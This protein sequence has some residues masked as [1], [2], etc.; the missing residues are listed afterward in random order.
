MRWID[1]GLV[2][3][4]ADWLH[5][6]GHST[7]RSTSW[8]ARFVVIFSC[9]VVISCTGPG[10]TLPLPGCGSQPETTSPHFT[11]PTTS[12]TQHDDG[13]QYPTNAPPLDYHPPTNSSST[14]SRSTSQS[15]PRPPPRQSGKRRR[16]ARAGSAH[17]LEKQSQIRPCRPRLSPDADRHESRAILRLHHRVV[18]LR[19][20]P[21]QH[22]TAVLRINYQ[23][24]R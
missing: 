8:A 12:I 15:T 2:K 22:E 24:R 5:S 23:Q 7:R 19:H 4:L 11:P 18:R 3:E 6:M 1:L 9:W 16:R 14:H 20:V 10:N 13:Q 21:G 17:V